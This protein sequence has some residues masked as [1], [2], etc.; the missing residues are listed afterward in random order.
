LYGIPIIYIDPRNTSKSCSKC[1][2]IN[3]T[4][5]SSKL[6][7]CS[8]CGHID[9]RDSN[10]A[11]NIASKGLYLVDHTDNVRELSAGLIDDSQTGQELEVA[12]AI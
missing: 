6:F 2:S 4:L 10:A 7:K 3:D 5:G 12:N 1:G 11:F 9:H 8:N